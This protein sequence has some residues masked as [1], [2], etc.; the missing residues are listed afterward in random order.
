MRIFVTGAAGLLGG[1]LVSRLLD[2]GHDVVALVRA[3]G[4]IARNDGRRLAVGERLTVAR[5]DVRTPGLGLAVDPP[6]PDLVIHA[7]A[8]T[9]FD[10]PAADHHAVNVAGTANVLD[11]AGATPVLHVSTAYVAG[12]RSGPVLEDELDAG[13]RFAN[14]YEASKA[15]AER[16]VRAHPGPWTIARPSIVVGDHRDGVIRDFDN[17]YLLLRLLAQGRLTTLPA[18]SDATLD[19]VPIDHVA[20]G[21]VALAEHPRAA[22]ETVHLVSGGQPV[23]PARLGAAIASVIGA[24]PG[25]VAPAAFRLAALRPAERR[26]HAAAAVALYT[27][28]LARRP[29]FDDT[30]ARA[31]TG[32]RCPVLDDAWLERLIAHAAARG[33]LAP[34]RARHA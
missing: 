31:L 30:R 23:T 19:F 7:A 20:A 16:L 2:R 6:R 1:E 5:G 32:R 4:T 21:L 14:G 34:R 12:D 10:A 11:F 22:G 15:A 9:A 18:A 26:L 25:F 33:E 28:Y 3:N 8:L 13:Q 29:A 24:R 17:L 27:A